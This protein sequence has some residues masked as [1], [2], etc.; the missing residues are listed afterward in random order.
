MAPR[1]A[2]LLVPYIMLLVAKYCAINSGPIPACTEAPPRKELKISSDGSFSFEL[3]PV[4]NPSKAVNSWAAVM[5]VDPTSSA[6]SY[7]CIVLF[8]RLKAT[9]PT[10]EPILRVLANPGWSRHCV[11]FKHLD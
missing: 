2:A 5:F 9:V 4:R 11:S 3:L 8:K 10:R 1:A 7:V 6:R